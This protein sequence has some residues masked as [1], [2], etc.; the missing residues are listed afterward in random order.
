VEDVYIFV[1]N[2]QSKIESR[3]VFYRS[4][5]GGKD[6]RSMALASDLPLWPGSNMITVVARANAEVKSVRTMF[7]YRDPTRTA[8]TQAP[9]AAAAAATR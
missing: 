1:S 3:K 7:V 4:N 5:R 8:Q 2:Q 9:T 6:A